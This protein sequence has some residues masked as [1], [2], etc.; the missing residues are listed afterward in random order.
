MENLMGTQIALLKTIGRNKLPSLFGTSHIFNDIRTLD[1]TIK[2][3]LN[4]NN[5]AITE[6]NDSLVVRE[7]IGLGIPFEEIKIHRLV[8]RGSEYIT[9]KFMIKNG[10]NG[11]EVLETAAYEHPLSTNSTQQTLTSLSRGED[12]TGFYFYTTIEINII[13]LEKISDMFSEKS[14]ELILAGDPA[15]LLENHIT[16]ENSKRSL[17]AY[18]VLSLL[19]LFKPEEKGLVEDT[20]ESIIWENNRTLADMVT[21]T[22]GNTQKITPIFKSFNLFNLKKNLV[23]IYDPFL[24]SMY[25]FNDQDATTITEGFNLFRP[26]D[27]HKDYLAR[28]TA[29]G[30]TGISSS[31]RH[32]TYK[33]ELINGGD[34]IPE[35]IIDL[36]EKRIN[37]LKK[38]KLDWLKI[39]W[40]KL[41]RRTVSNPNFTSLVYFNLLN[42]F[43]SKYN[44]PLGV[45]GGNQ[46]FP[47]ETFPFYLFREVFNIET[48]KFFNVEVP[49]NYMDALQ[50]IKF[51][52]FICSIYSRNAK[53]TIEKSSNLF[54][55]DH[56]SKYSLSDTNQRRL[57]FP[58]QIN[59]GTGART[60]FNKKNPSI[61]I[62]NDTEYNI[63]TWRS[64]V[65]KIIKT[66]VA[67]GEWFPEKNNSLT[68]FILEPESKFEALKLKHYL[69]L[70]PCS[71]GLQNLI[72]DTKIPVVRRKSNKVSVTPPVN[73]IINVRKF[74][75]GSKKLRSVK[76]DMADLDMKHNLFIRYTH[77]KQTVDVFNGVGLSLTRGIQDRINTWVKMIGNTNINRRIIYVS[78][79]NY[80]KIKST[81]TDAQTFDEYITDP[82]N[83]WALAQPLYKF[84]LIQK[85]TDYHSALNRIKSFI[86]RTWDIFIN[87][88]LKSNSSNSN[89]AIRPFFEAGLQDFING[90]APELQNILVKFLS[91]LPHT[92][93]KSDC[94][95]RVPGIHTCELFIPSPT[96]IDYKIMQSIIPTDV[97]IIKPV[98]ILKLIDSDKSI[99]AL[100]VF[101]AM[102]HKLKSTEGLLETELCNRDL[103]SGQ[104]YNLY[105]NASL[106]QA[107]TLSLARLEKAVI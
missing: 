89:K 4:L 70:R 87:P 104:N 35:G 51:A 80:K 94:Q 17:F 7:L 37:D 33:T 74:S 32:R 65:R 63:S 101:S 43:L 26:E 69:K 103:V 99:H 9:Q 102:C 34:S 18:S 28:T 11:V 29:I 57:T 98:D 56:M 13:I 76:I 22:G 79:S 59:T 45:N 16:N 90:T 93:V 107:V 66:K 46:H 54:M 86:S 71:F 97:D 78:E 64:K 41:V 53:F 100:T 83:T 88:T 39:R 92:L 47:S 5:L 73:N 12:I 50:K 105:I 3:P 77:T 1:C 30:L 82:Q 25:L 10:L 31:R 42:A 2:L 52:P 8:K 67:D 24:Q 58:Y 38:I 21:F 49:S 106:R 61:I 95:Y 15:F 14:K 84:I 68:V 81:Y 85:T 60:L 91:N 96:D 19:A 6:L 75:P 23:N 20:L 44:N 72:M 55:A 36:V 27:Y 40:E 62:V 48:T